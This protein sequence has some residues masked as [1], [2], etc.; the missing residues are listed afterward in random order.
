[1]DPT[2]IPLHRCPDLEMLIDTPK[3]YHAAHT[4]RIWLLNNLQEGVFLRL[5]QFLPKH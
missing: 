3:G 4:N 1:M 2:R 5:R